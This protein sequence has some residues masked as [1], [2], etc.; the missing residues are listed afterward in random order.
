M[1]KSIKYLFSVLLILA[2]ARMTS[3]HVEMDYPKGGETF[4]PGE[5]VEVKWRVTVEH[6]P[7][8]W[9]LF[10]S[11]DGGA[12][13]ELIS[14][15]PIQQLEYD[16]VVPEQYTQT[17]R[18]KIVQDNDTQDDYEDVSGDF[19]IESTTPVNLNNTLQFK[20]YPN[21]PNPF[22]SNTTIRFDLPEKANVIISLYT[23]EGRKVTTL[24]DSETPAGRH[25]YLF[26]RGG[27]PKGIYLYRIETGDFADTKKML[28]LN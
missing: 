17:G 8:D 3:A 13:W 23:L 5:T 25:T 27:S 22:R 11:S 16:W 2:F 26:E 7:V 20:L 4:T 15:M 9:D 19:T 28:I 14:S 12:S 6:D 18:L 21:F 24:L 10:F 1:N